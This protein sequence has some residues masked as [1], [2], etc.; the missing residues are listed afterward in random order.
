LQKLAILSNDEIHCK[1]FG[2]SSNDGV[3]LSAALLLVK[4]NSID[5]RRLPAQFRNFGIL[6]HESVEVSYL[7]FAKV[8]IQLFEYLE[9]N[10]HPEGTDL[11]QQCVAVLQ[12]PLAA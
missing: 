7:I 1:C 2:M 9:R 6:I 3:T 12:A 8:E 5:W 10:D 4:P 11:I